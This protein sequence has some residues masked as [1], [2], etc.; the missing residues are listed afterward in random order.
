[1]GATGL[2]PVTLSY[3]NSFFSYENGSRGLGA[4]R[5]FGFHCT[6]IQGIIILQSLV[7]CWPQYTNLKVTAPGLHQRMDGGP[8]R[9]EV[10]EEGDLEG[11]K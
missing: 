1:M 4:V 9:M 7:L 2:S 5:S 8:G 10:W 3:E 6:V 11:W